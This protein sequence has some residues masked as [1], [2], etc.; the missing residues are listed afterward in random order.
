M[1]DSSP[2]DDFLDWLLVLPKPLETAFWQEI[3][4]YEQERKVAYITS[5]QRI[6]REEGR[7]EG[8]ADLVCE[9]VYAQLGDLPADLRTQ[10]EQLE[11]EQIKA[12]GRSLLKFSKL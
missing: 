5:V 7:Q 2:N 4:T 12:L 8:M 1:P 10:I 9:Q 11:P 3:K 6:G